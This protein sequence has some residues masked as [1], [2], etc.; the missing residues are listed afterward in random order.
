MV[1][2]RV[3]GKLVPIE[4]VLHNG[5]R[6][7]IITSQ[8]SK[9]PSRDWLKVVKSTQAKNRINRWFRMEKK[10]DNI[11]RGHE[12]LAGYIKNKG[13]NPSDVVKP[14]YQK[15]IM[16]KYGFQDWDS[17]LAAIGHG[18]LKEGQVFNK[19]VECYE[20]DRKASMTDAEVIAGVDA[21]GENAAVKQA[22]KKGGIT[23]RGIHDVAV[24]FSHCCSPIPG[25][26]IV[27][28]VTRGRGI[29]IH[30]TDCINIMNLPESER[31]RLI[32][33]EWAPDSA[34]DER[35]PVGISV[36]ANNRVGLL[37][38]LSKI[39]TSL[40]IIISA[41]IVRRSRKDDT[42]TVDMTFSVR[43]K[44]ELLELAAK[45][46]QVPSVIDVERAKG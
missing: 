38:D 32:E 41:P 42:A 11:L 26:E 35:Y 2:A 29:T 6:V 36:Y 33:A 24:H 13:Y 10:E 15:K 4:T 21:P 44:S 1:G 25:D 20:K 16:Q 5:D 8:N 30:R 9:G 39:L 23:V 46:K 34:S 14:D 19:L 43:S 27:G 17:V 40:G 31:E 22:S 28:F 7:E 37:V 12:L 3:N 45:V 18:G